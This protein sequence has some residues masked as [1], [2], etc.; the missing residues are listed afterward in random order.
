MNISVEQPAHSRI[1]VPNLLLRLEGLTILAAA[2]LLYRQQ[3]AGWLLF[4]LLLLAPDL[5][6][7]G[8]V[9]DTRVGALTYNAL[10]TLLAPLLLAAVAGWLSSGLLLSLA[11]IWLAHIGLDRAL[12]YGLK[13][14]DSFHGNHLTAL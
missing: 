9:V 11:L 12:G 10:H 14:G 8:Y 2:I 5:G 3:D 6:M 13:Y 4:L 7:L 1:T